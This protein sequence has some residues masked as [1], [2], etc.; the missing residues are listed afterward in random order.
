MS[1]RIS[2]VANAVCQ[3]AIR[4]EIKRLEAVGPRF[5]STIKALQACLDDLRKDAC[6]VQDRAT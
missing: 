6:A 2:F 5:E 3:I 1:A 4:A